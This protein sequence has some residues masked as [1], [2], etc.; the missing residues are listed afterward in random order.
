MKSIIIYTSTHKMNTEKVAHAMAA[1]MGAAVRRTAE[2]KPADLEGYDLVGFGS[3]IYGFDVAAELR[4]LVES[5]PSSPGRRVFLFTTS[6]SGKAGNSRK[7]R[8]L[9][10]SKGFNVAS[11][12][13]CHGYSVFLGGLLKLRKGCPTTDELEGARALARQ[14]KN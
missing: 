8:K 6:G 1:E 7:F 4:T 3:G 11:E 14:L 12:F 2:T 10:E 5:M 9:L 13:H